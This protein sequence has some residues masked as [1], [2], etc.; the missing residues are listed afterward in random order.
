[1]LPAG[2]QTRV[3]ATGNC[4]AE[5]FKNIFSC[6]L[7][8]ENPNT[9]GRNAISTCATGKQQKRFPA[10]P[11]SIYCCYCIPA[12]L[13][14]FLTTRFRYVTRCAV[15][16]SQKD[17]SRCQSIDSSKAHRDTSAFDCCTTRYNHFASPKYQMIA[18]L[19]LFAQNQ[20]MCDGRIFSQG[21]DISGFF[22][23]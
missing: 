16:S 14:H 8:R 17:E 20:T 2:L 9:N 12:F 6:S 23:R 5:I 10:R 18:T 21:G 3:E 1:M 13:K 7:S 22:Q 15:T 11:G 4:P 19:L